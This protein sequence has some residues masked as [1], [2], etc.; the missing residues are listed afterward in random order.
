[1]FFQ[2]SRILPKFVKRAK[3]PTSGTLSEEMELNEKNPREVF[4]ANMTN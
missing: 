1:M 2:N 4:V 3:H